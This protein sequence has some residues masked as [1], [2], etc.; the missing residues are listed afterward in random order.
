IKTKGLFAL[1]VDDEIWQDIGLDDE[2]PQGQPPPWLSDT[3]VRDGIVALLERDRSVEE[4]RRLKHEGHSIR[5]WLAE[6]WAV[7][8]TAINECD[9]ESLKY[10]LNIRRLYLRDVCSTWQK[11]LV[12][13][14]DGDSNPMPRWG[15]SPEEL[16]AAQ[17]D[18]VT[19]FIT[20][21][22]SDDDDGLSDIEMDEV[23]LAL[24]DA[25]EA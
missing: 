1:N 23:D 21:D 16:Y 7:V 12:N 24:F 20:D 2:S 4:M 13:I 14:E 19:A 11:S 9:D 25:V 18:A 22:M 10:F 8:M 17:V 15:P 5:L 3:N 6:E